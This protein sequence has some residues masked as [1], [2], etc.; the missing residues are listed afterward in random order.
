[1]TNGMGFPYLDMTAL[2]SP[3]HWIKIFKVISTLQY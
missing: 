3:V 2:L 1:M